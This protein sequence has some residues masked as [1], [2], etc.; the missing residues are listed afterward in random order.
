MSSNGDVKLT[1]RECGG[2]FIFT[3]SE[4]DFYDLKGFPPPGRCREC[5]SVPN[6]HNH[7]RTCT[8]CGVKLDKEGPVF[9]TTCLKNAQL[10][11]ERKAKQ[12][13][14]AAKSAECKLTDTE[15]RNAELE[16]SLFQTRKLAEELEVRVSNLSHDLKKARECYIASG[17][18]KPLLKSIEERLKDLESAQRESDRRISRLIHAMQERYEDTNLVDLIKRSLAP[19]RGQSIQS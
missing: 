17:W 16:E 3:K 15:S 14:K 7:H 18:L 13:H 12:E 5:R 8:Q 2:I 10:V 4:Q 11:L 9:C 19:Y 1:C 6:N